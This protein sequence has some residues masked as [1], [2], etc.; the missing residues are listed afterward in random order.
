ME[1][2]R[3]NT[4]KSIFRV[5]TWYLQVEKRLQ[6]FMKNGNLSFQ[7]NEPGDCEK[8]SV[9]V[10][11]VPFITTRHID[12]SKSLFF[13]LDLMLKFL[14]FT[15]RCRKKRKLSWFDN[16]SENS[17]VI[18]R[19]SLPRISYKQASFRLSQGR[20]GNITNRTFLFYQASQWG[21]LNRLENQHTA[22]LAF[23]GFQTHTMIRTKPLD[24]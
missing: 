23:T 19:N 13:H 20:I 22:F 17:L 5:V 16:L 2:V 6:N 1:S 4:W 7:L 8:T 14:S 3:G 9:D 21:N 12:G 11:T 10:Y 15:N 18:K 24:Q